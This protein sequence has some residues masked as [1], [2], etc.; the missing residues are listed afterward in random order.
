MNEICLVR[1]NVM[2]TSLE[3]AL[4]THTHTHV[5]VNRARA[6]MAATMFLGLARTMAPGSSSMTTRYCVL[7][8]YLFV[9][10]AGAFFVFLVMAMPLGLY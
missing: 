8:W 10:F 1:E 7:W 9:F 4:D 6:Q 5:G 3:A 2:L